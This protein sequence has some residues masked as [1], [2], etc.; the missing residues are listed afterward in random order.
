MTVTVDESHVGVTTY[1][2]L[3]GTKQEILDELHEKAKG[4]AG[5]KILGFYYD[6]SNDAVAIR[7]LDPV[8]V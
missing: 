5:F 2:I 8:N 6:G 1:A 4:K 3:S 7:Y